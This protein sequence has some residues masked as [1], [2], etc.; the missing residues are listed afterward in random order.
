MK[1]IFKNDLRKYLVVTA[2]IIITL[3]G[4]TIR[5]FTITA[6]IQVDFL[7]NDNS[8]GTFEGKKIEWTRENNNHYFI[9]K[10]FT[11]HGYKKKTLSRIRIGCT[12]G[13]IQKIKEFANLSSNLYFKFECNIFNQSNGKLTAIYKDN[14]WSNINGDYFFK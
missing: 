4:V 2:L 7:G 1:K 10:N 3:F 12:E 6:T 14:P 8:I 11:L 9:L 5:P 13:Q